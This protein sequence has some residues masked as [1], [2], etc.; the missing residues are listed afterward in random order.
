MRNLL[1]PFKKIVYNP[2]LEKLS[3]HMDYL[4]ILGSTECGNTRCDYF[5]E[6]K[7]NLKKDYAGIVVETTGIEK[8]IQHWGCNRQLLMEGI[9]VDYFPNTEN[10]V[11]KETKYELHLYI[12]DENEQY[13]YDSNAHMVN[14]F[15]K[16]IDF[17]LLVSGLS[18]V[19]KDTCGYTKQYK[20]DLTIY[21]MTLFSY[22]YGII[23]NHEINAP[24][25]VKN[26]VGGINA[27]NK[28]YL[29]DSCYHALYFTLFVWGVILCNSNATIII[30]FSPNLFHA[31]IQVLNCC[32]K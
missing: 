24:V 11:N 14:L 2:T 4:Q 7:L 28:R 9:A 13:S 8:Q 1:I 6:K 20:C 21:L 27:T 31:T 32:V 17:G 5:Q 30:F 18:I 10:L 23:M 22:L 29:K 25:N 15:K 12:I 26:V 16:Y 19:W 3:F